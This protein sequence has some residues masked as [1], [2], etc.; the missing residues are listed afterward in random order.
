MNICNLKYDHVSCG[1]H[2]RIQYW[3]CKVQMARNVSAVIRSVRVLK[4]K[5]NEARSS[6]DRGQVELTEAGAVG[7]TR[8]SL[9][10]RL[11][12]PCFEFSLLS[13]PRILLS[14]AFSLQN[15]IL[16]LSDRH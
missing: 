14:S 6:D 13:M 11:L 7:F 3:I 8:C 5:D 12:R 9:G 2:W 15:Q 4:R 10:L 16:Q 1:G